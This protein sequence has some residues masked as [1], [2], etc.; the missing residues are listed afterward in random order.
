MGSRFILP[1]SLN[2]LCRVDGGGERRVSG[3]FRGWTLDFAAMER[4]VLGA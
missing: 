4:R 2:G 3:R 1:G